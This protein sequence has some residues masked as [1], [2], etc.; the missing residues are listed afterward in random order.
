MK[1]RRVVAELFHAD[2]RKDMTKLIVAFRLKVDY[3]T[4]TQTRTH[5][6]TLSEL[7]FLPRN[8]TAFEI[9]LLCQD[10]KNGYVEE[11]DVSTKVI[12]YFKT[13]LCRNRFRNL[14]FPLLLLGESN[15]SDGVRT[16][17]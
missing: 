7:Y 10:C 15:P 4:H 14:R 12:A 1:I 13:E 11:N 8:D 16:I 3:L 6:M 2:R 9:I 5:S 17:D